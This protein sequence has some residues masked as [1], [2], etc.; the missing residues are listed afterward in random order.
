MP[1]KRKA[2]NKLKQLSR[3]ADYFVKDV[4][5]AYTDNLKGCVLL[6]KKHKRLIPPD[7]REGK[8]AVA[9]L[10]RPHRWSCLI[11]ALGLDGKTEYFKSELIETTERYFHDDLGP[12]LEEH[13][14]KLTK[15]MNPNH[16]CGLAWLASPTGGD[17]DE[18]EVAEILTNLE[19]WA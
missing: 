8:V 12:V 2:Y 17:I 18:A 13:H 16:F 10:A 14:L 6:H 11:V 5:V 4:I 1:K 9:S 19:A 3:A 7:S 15:E